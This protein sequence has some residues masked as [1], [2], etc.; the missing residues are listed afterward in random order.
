M[1]TKLSHQTIVNLAEGKRAAESLGRGSGSMFFWRERGVIHFYYRYYKEKNPVLILI[2]SYKENRRSKGLTLQE[3][4]DKA[5]ELARVRR[6]IGQRDLK[7]YLELEN[8]KAKA[9]QEEERRQRE[10]EASHGTFADLLENYLNYL[11]K[12]GRESVKDVLHIY[13]KNVYRPHRALL[14]K[15]ARE[16]TP[17]DIVDILAPIHERGS[18]TQ[19]NRCRAY[20]HA[21]F[22]EAAKSDYDPARRGEK[23][24]HLTGNPVTLV[25]KDPTAENADDRILSYDELRDFYLNIEQTFHVGPILGSLAKLMIATAGQRPKMLIRTQWRDYD[26]ER[27]TLTLTEKKGRER[28]TRPHIIPL[29]ARAIRIL[30]NLQAHNGDLDGPFYSAPGQAVRLDSL[31]NVFVRWH[32]RRT[33]EAQAMF[34]PEPEKF[35]ARDIRRTANYLLTDA[36]VRPEDSNLL[37]SHGQTGVVIKHYDR[38][39]HLPTKLKAMRR[40][41]RLLSR[42]ITK[43]RRVIEHMTYEYG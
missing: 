43:K 6:E 20:L 23:R 40:Y 41:E 25:R 34:L 19:S 18:V 21:A 11:E 9:A 3:C 35:T 4:R 26:F 33:K 7:E 2:D 12:N 1:A 38:H 13:T 28:R 31:K 36:G 29:T 5:F 22:A 24:F 42:M 32:E 30:R 10:I 15:K 8:L 16:I 17:D 27:R 39:H 37:Q 14:A